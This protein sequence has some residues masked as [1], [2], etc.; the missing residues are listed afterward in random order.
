[1]RGRPIIVAALALVVAALSACGSSS[2]TG[3]STST[4]STARPVGGTT[5]QIRDYA[6]SPASLQVKVGAT[7]T[8]TNADEVAH[9][10]T[11]KDKS[12]DTGR[13][14]PGKS[15]TITLRTAGTFAYLCSFHPYMQGSIQV[16][17]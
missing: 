2:S 9:T 13:L 5:I 15:A 7:I 8:V 6:F 11:A 3:T 17:S 12:F 16:T 1:M 10:L 4:A 14:E